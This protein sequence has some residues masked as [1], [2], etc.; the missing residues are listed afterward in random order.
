MIFKL[1]NVYMCV[2][3]PDIVWNC[4]KY[5]SFAVTRI[6]PLMKFI[7]SEVNLGRREVVNPSAALFASTLCFTT[8]G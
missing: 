5:V 4:I 3:S 8:L 7:S 1:G 6:L 2:L